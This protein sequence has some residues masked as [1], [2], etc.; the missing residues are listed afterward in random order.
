MPA[1]MCIISVVLRCFFRRGTCGNRRPT[2]QVHNKHEPVG[3]LICSSRG[4]DLSSISGKIQ[5]FK[6][7]V[8]GQLAVL[9]AFCRY[10]TCF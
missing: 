5:D 4:I 8:D 7:S 9:S 1:I 6:I 2:G 3:H 10:Y